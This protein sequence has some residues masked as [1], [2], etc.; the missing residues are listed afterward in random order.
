MFSFPRNPKIWHL[1]MPDYR[2]AVKDSSAEVR[3]ITLLAASKAGISEDDPIYALFVGMTELVNAKTIGTNGEVKGI[4]Q[5][6]A[7]LTRTVE[8]IKAPETNPTNVW[9]RIVLSIGIVAVLLAL[10]FLAGV[11]YVS[12]QT[13]AR[14]DRIINSQPA[15]A[16]ATTALSA[17]AGSITI[18]PIKGPDGRQ[19]RGIIVRPG[20]LKQDISTDGAVLLTL[21]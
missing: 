15:A 17:H 14:V 3:E 2:T 16:Q 7:E 18:G 21:P 10:G 11:L 9:R 8:Y 19:A 5:R 13:D 12:R 6:L 1:P 20:D 4:Q